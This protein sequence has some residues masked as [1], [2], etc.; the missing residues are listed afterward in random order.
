ME[1]LRQGIAE[2]ARRDQE[3]AK[4]VRPV[5]CDL[6]SLASVRA[7]AE[8]VRALGR[9]IDALVLCAGRFL[10]APFALTADGIEQARR[11][12]LCGCVVWFWRARLACRG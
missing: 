1:H 4:R 5:V 2:V 9:P 3:A 10:D 6:E 7:A 12:C 8:R 11:W